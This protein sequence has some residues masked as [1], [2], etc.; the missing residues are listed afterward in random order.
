MASGAASWTSI[1]FGAR[2]PCFVT[3]SA[4]ASSAHAIGTAAA[5]I[6]AG[7]VDVA[8][9]GGTEAP[10]DHGTLTAWDA[11][12]VMSRT[13]CRPF[14]QGRDGLM[15]SEGAGI[16]VLEAEAHARARG[17]A[18]DIELAGW[19][20]GADARD[21]FA[22][23][24]DGMAAAMRDALAAA[25]IEPQAIDWINAHGTATR[26]NDIAE[27]EALRAVFGADACPPTTSTKG[28][29][30]H[31]LGASGGLEAVA[32]VLAMRNNLAPPTAGFLEADPECPI[33]CIPGAARPMRIDA[34]LS[35]SFAFGGLNASLAFRRLRSAA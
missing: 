30:G 9:T 31:A 28:V 20:A 7:V 10:L 13:V 3:S 34:A 27:V 24:P 17:R 1:A 33:D 2:G 15:I 35:N 19:A 26:A 8:V 23:S 22:P 5:L 4:C 32:T 25:G 6:R 12:K 14:S 29:H 21:L 16:I 11:M 18:D